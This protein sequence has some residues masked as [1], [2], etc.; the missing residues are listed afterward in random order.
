[1]SD[2]AGKAKDFL[3]SDK[4]EKASDGALDKGA[5]AI[6]KATGGGHGEQ[7]DKARDAAD[8]KLGG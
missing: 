2:L 7:V 8:G 5:D 1:M 6:E 4:G 3:S